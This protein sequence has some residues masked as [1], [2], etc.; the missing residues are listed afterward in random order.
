MYFGDTSGVRR[1]KSAKFSTKRKELLL[2][3]VRFPALGAGSTSLHCIVIGSF[4]SSLH[5]DL[6]KQL[7]V[8]IEKYSNCYFF[9]TFFK[10][11]IN[12]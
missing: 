7:L 12:T 5:C 4:Y 6:S 11:N 2:T 9:F 10:L 1:K 3:P 8:S